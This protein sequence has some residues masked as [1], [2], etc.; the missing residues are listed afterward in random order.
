MTRSAHQNS[1]RARRRRSRRS[2]SRKRRFSRVASRYARSHQPGIAR[3][4]NRDDPN[5]PIARQFV[6][7]MAE[8]SSCRKSVPIR[9]ATAR[10][11]RLPASSTVIRTGAPEG[12]SC[13]PVYCRFCFRREMVGPEGLGTLAPAE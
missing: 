6:P 10:T 13:L 11:A 4:V 12:G 2:E 7:D 5:D 3:L 1:A 8:L 9:S